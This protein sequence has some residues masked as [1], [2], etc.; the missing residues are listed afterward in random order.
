MQTIQPNQSLFPS[1]NQPPS[2]RCSTMSWALDGELLDSCSMKTCRVFTLI[3]QELGV[4]NTGD[5]KEPPFL[6]GKGKWRPKNWWFLSFFWK[7]KNTHLFWVFIYSFYHIAFFGYLEFLNSPYLE[8]K[9]YT[10]TPVS[11]S[12]KELHR[13]MF[14]GTNTP[15]KRSSKHQELPTFAS[16]TSIGKLEE[17]KS[18]DC[19]IDMGL[20]SKTS[21]RAVEPV[22][23]LLFG[24][25]RPWWAS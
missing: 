13:K 15:R 19:S 18:R 11:T 1:T 7:L 4:E 24:F 14:G 23:P 8:Q 17:P 25:H 12:I 9:K 20:R 5:P 22:E 21:A 2:I 16:S 10:N 6:G 3:C